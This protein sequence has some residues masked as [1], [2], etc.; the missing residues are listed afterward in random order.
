MKWRQLEVKSA[1]HPS[2]TVFQS[3]MFFQE[4]GRKDKWGPMQ[5]GPQHR[6]PSP[7]RILRRCSAG[8]HGGYSRDRMLGKASGV[9]RSW[10]DLGLNFPFTPMSYATLG[11]MLELSGHN[12]P[13]QETVKITPLHENS[14]HWST[15]VSSPLSSMT[16]TWV[17][18]LNWERNGQIVPHT[19]LLSSLPIKKKVMSVWCEDYIQV[20]G[21]ILLS[22]L[23]WTGT[24]E[25][26]P[27]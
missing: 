10:A 8:W 26:R 25:H 6:A 18:G 2:H 7:F 13:T 27:V 17:S 5:G 1:C 21:S 9:V 24:E 11:K 3:V 15:T 23:R 22:D 14:A 12:F 19:L 16:W 4:K 20:S